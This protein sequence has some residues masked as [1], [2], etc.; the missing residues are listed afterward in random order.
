VLSRGENYEYS[1]GAMIRDNYYEEKGEFKMNIAILYVLKASYSGQIFQEW[2]HYKKDNGAAIQVVEIT[3][4]IMD[5]L[6]YSGENCKNDIGAAIEAVK[7]TRKIME[8]LF[9][10]GENCK[11]DLELLLK[12]WKLQER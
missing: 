11:K 4:K 8:L 7:I 2:L 10:S 9:Y 3:R 12:R 1:C 5:L 6:F